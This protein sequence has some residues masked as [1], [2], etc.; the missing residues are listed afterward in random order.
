MKQFGGRWSEILRYGQARGAF[1][2]RRLT[3]VKARC[4]YAL[5]KIGQ[6]I[7]QLPQFTSE[8]LLAALQQPI[9][10]QSLTSP[11]HFSAP[12]HNP[13]PNDENSPQ[14]AE[15]SLSAGANATGAVAL[16]PSLAL[17]AGSSFEGAGSLNAAL[18]GRGR[19]RQ[20]R[21]RGSRSV[22]PNPRL[23]AHSNSTESA[24][25]LSTERLPFGL[26][27]G[28]LARG[29][30][31]PG[32]PR[33]SRG[34]RPVAR[35]SMPTMASSVSNAAMMIFNFPLSASASLADAQTSELPLSSCPIFPTPALSPNDQNSIPLPAVSTTTNN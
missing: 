21:P 3:T 35:V 15:K 1:R 23:N 22:L 12:N 19:G 32:R 30:G 29:R 24:L 5:R 9:N 16:P 20:R 8:Q 18:R 13:K 6:S 14:R 10:E 27:A 33:G 4:V 11:P 26:G 2:E 34:L 17:P 7:E 25:D 28:T 31:R